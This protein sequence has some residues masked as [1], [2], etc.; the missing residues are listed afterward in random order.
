V[1]ECKTN[2]VGFGVKW[3]GTD[4]W[5]NVGY[6]SIEC[7]PTGIKDSEITS[8]ETRLPVSANHYRNFLDAVKSRQ[9]PIEPVEVGHRTA[10]FCHLGNM[11]MIL[12]RKING[13][14]TRRK[15]SGDVEV[16]GVAPISPLRRALILRHVAERLEL[17]AYQSLKA[18]SAFTEFSRLGGRQLRVCAEIKAAGHC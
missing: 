12:G 13:T 16:A 8:G 6:R 5:L 18:A 1:L 3:I 17:S 7:E 10:K 14:R 9:D 4:G 11:A 15:L 2:K